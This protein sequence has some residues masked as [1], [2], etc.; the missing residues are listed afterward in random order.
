M[1]KNSITI[2]VKGETGSGKTEVCE[3]IHN[4]L[5][6]YYGEN[7]TVVATDLEKER[8]SAH[9]GILDDAKFTGQSCLMK[10]TTITLTETNVVKSLACVAI[11]P[12]HMDMDLGE[13]ISLTPVKPYLVPVDLSDAT[14]GKGF[15]ALVSTWCNLSQ[16]VNLATA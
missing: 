6:A 2:E 15:T 16:P 5:T 10:D 3:L 9:M 11:E 7:V 8:R 13:G 12:I 14:V 4:A 1:K